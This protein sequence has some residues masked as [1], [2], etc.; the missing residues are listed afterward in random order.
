[1]AVADRGAHLP[2]SE[3]Q[4]LAPRPVSHAAP[5]SRHDDLVVTLAAVADAAIVHGS[6]EVVGNRMWISR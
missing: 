2:R 4:H 3:I 5:L 6:L 1:M